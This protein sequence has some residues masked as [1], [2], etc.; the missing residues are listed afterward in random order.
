MRITVLSTITILIISILAY[1]Q[2]SPEMPP[3][4]AFPHGSVT[5][6]VTDRQSKA[7]IRDVKV[8]MTKNGFSLGVYAETDADGKFTIENAPVG[9]F[10]LSISEEKYLPKVILNIRVKEGE[11]VASVKIAISMITPITVGDE[12]RDFTLPTIK[13]GLVTL[14]DFFN[15]KIVV[16]A[17]SNPYG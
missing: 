13:G 14:S 11:V 17:I 8:E 6:V 5:G 7:P 10:D 3:E 4:V 1:G 15:K 9:V 2:E 12:A 16:F